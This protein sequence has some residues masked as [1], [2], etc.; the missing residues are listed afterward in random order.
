MAGQAPDV[1]LI[2]CDRMRAHA[3]GAYGNGLCRRPHLDRLVHESTTFRHAMSNC[4]ACVPAR[5]IRMS[6]QYAR[7]CTGGIFN[8]AKFWPFNDQ[9]HRLRDP[10]MPEQ[11]R[12]PCN[13]S[14]VVRSKPTRR[15]WPMEPHGG[16][17]RRT[18]GHL[19]GSN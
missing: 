9:R 14:F 17:S 11:I 4:P 1:V 7:T 13:V 3:V 2:V 19:M 15:A 8:I 6:G 18:V 5:S 16:G 12:A 10:T